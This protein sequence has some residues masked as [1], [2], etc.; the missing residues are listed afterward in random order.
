[1]TFTNGQENQVLFIIQ[2]II[3]DDLLGWQCTVRESKTVRENPPAERFRFLT[4]F[5]GRSGESYYPGV[6]TQV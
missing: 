6:I 4:A 5:L 2:G 1:M 3:S